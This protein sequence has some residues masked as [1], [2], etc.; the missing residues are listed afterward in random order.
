M[1]PPWSGSSRSVTLVAAVPQTLGWL[2]MHT[3]TWSLWL[4]LGVSAAPST[5][6]VRVLRLA[7]SSTAGVAGS[8]VHEK[9]TPREA[10][11]PGMAG[12]HEATEAYA[13]SATLR[14][15]LT[16]I[17]GGAWMVTVGM[18]SVLR[19]TVTYLG[20]EV[21]PRKLDTTRRKVKVQPSLSSSGVKMTRSTLPRPT[22]L[23]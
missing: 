8:A 19:T 20:S 22:S 13:V 15:A 6:S 12:K 11:S 16:C 17:T 3:V 1:I 14:S 5:L 10:L 4:T 21:N 18:G 9:V 2:A 23:G 7:G